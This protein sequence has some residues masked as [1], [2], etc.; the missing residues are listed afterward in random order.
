LG[1]LLSKASLAGLSGAFKERKKKLTYQLMEEPSLLNAKS[2]ET[3]FSDNAVSG[4]ASAREQDFTG[5]GFTGVVISGHMHWISGTD[6]V[7]VVIGR[8]A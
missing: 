1:P 8:L 6:V 2:L 5:L 3:V 4:R 7:F